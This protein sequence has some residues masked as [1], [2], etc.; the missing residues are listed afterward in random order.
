VRIKIESN[1]NAVVTD[2]EGKPILEYK[3]DG[4]K[5]EAD[6]KGLVQFGKQVQS[7]IEEVMAS[8]EVQKALEEARTSTQQ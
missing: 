1:I 5:L 2:A 3:I 8:E 7:T 6:V 4:F